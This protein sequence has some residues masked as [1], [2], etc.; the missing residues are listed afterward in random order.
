M[1]RLRMSTE[2][3]SLLSAAIRWGSDSKIS[4]IEYELEDGSTLGARFS[5]RGKIARFFGK[6]ACWLNFDGIQFRPA[7]ANRKQ[8]TVIHATFAGIEDAF[9]WLAHYR[10]GRPYDL[11]G[12]L[13]IITARGWSDNNS[14]FCSKAIQES[15]TSIGTPLQR[16]EPQAT[17]PRDIEIS[18]AI[19][20]L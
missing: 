6:P 7:S 11:L 17:K 12:I 10:L 2:K 16:C 18:L 4:H 19:T 20:L 15:A 13:G 8:T 9:N 14:S 5:L 3:W 1:I